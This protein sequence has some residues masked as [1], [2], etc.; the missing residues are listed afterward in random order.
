LTVPGHKRVVDLEQ[1]TL[2]IVE[3]EFWIQDLLIV[4]LTPCLLDGSGLD[5]VSPLSN[6][7][8]VNPGLFEL[9]HLIYS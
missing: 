4:D 2:T 8:C 1:E 7:L 9:L 6:Y 3:I 5:R